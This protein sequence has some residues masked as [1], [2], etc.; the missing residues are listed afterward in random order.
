[1][2]MFD[3]DLNFGE[4][5]EPGD[6]F[7]LTGLQYVGK[8]NTRNGEAEKS[9]VTVCTR[10]SYPKQERYSF[11]GIGVANMARKAE[12]SDFPVVVEYYY[13]D[14][15]DG[16][17]LKLFARV[18]VTPGEFIKGNDG[19]PADVSLQAALNAPGGAQDTGNADVAF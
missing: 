14:R 8:I 13:Q 15:P 10:E 2:G 9:I 3:Q 7:V 1:M 17:T 6:R 18:N 5:F 19:P 12:A 11:L 16:K 4:N